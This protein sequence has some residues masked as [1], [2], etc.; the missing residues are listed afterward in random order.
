MRCPRH[1]HQP[2]SAWLSQT[3]SL[4]QDTF[5]R[6]CVQK[7]KLFSYY[8]LVRFGAGSSILTMWVMAGSGALNQLHLQQCL[9]RM[10]LPQALHMLHQAHVLRHVGKRSHPRPQVPECQPPPACGLASIIH[11]NDPW[12]LDR[13]VALRQG[14]L[15]HCS[16][17]HWRADGDELERSSAAMRLAQRT[18]SSIRVN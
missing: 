8:Q 13:S 7:M 3:S 17:E 1:V 2:V 9:A 5:W 12:L 10:H 18:L 14:L 16:L 4:S 11:D 6:G 15:F